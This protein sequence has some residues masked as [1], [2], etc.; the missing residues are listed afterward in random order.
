MK[1]GDRV[2][3]TTTTTG[4]G[5]VTLAGAASS[6]LAFS[7]IY[8]IGERV[9]YFIIDANGTDWEVGEG[10]LTGSTTL[11]RTEILASSNSGNAITLSAGTH[12][13]ADGMPATF[14]TQL[15]TIGEILAMATGQAMP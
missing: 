15:Q 14:A 2:K 5:S 13:V 12:T 9:P 3:E 6:F 10:T 8:S 1:F 4:T 11:A 7:S